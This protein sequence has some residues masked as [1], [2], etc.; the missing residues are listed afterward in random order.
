MRAR[1][2]GSKLGVVRWRG[3]ILCFLVYMYSIVCVLQTTFV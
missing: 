2:L 1:R 3:N